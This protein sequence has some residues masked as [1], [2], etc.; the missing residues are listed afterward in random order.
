MLR[1][2]FSTQPLVHVPSCTC[3]CLKLLPFPLSS[4]NK[5]K[6]CYMLQFTVIFLICFTLRIAISFAL[7][8]N[9]QET[10]TTIKI[11]VQTAVTKYIYKKNY[12][13]HHA[14]RQ[15]TSGFLSVCPVKHVGNVNE[16]HGCTLSMRA[17]VP[18]GQVICKSML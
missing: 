18:Q 13:F 7:S 3:V 12:Q 17:P 11:T 5:Q 2:L 4:L 14:P 16:K 15:T 6:G 9:D 8:V 10:S 1:F